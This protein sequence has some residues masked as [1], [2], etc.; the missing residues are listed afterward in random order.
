MTRETYMDH[1]SFE[2]F[3]GGYGGIT[4]REEFVIKFLLI[5]PPGSDENVLEFFLF[6]VYM[7]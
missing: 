7:Y 2:G 6:N 3:W 4:L 1:R 5:E